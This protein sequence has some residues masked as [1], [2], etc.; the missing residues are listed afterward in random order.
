MFYH[1]GGQKTTGKG[2][3]WSSVLAQRKW[4]SLPG[5]LVFL[6]CLVVSDEYPIRP[7]R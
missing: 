7:T 3:C 6:V 1:L 5:L 2:G 4:A